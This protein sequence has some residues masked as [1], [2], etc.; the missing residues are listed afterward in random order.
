MQRK[1]FFGK[2]FDCIIFYKKNEK[3]VSKKN[4][5]NKMEI[6]GDKKTP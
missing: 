4:V 6:F 2:N 5:G 1:S 3:G